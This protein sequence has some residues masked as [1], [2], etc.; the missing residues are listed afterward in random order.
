LPQRHGIL[1][2]AGAVNGKTPT[3]SP[4]IAVVT[5]CNVYKGMCHKIRLIR[6]GGAPGCRG[7]VP[8]VTAVSAI[9]NVR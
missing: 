3:D 4:Q 9:L 2:V 7:A 6:Q 8:C 5:H 1:V